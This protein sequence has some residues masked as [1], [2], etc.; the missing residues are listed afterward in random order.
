MQLRSY[1][2]TPWLLLWS[3]REVR[4]QQAL[5]PRKYVTS[6]HPW[7]RHCVNLALFGNSSC[8]K[9]STNAKFRDST[10]TLTQTIGLGISL[11]SDSRIKGHRAR[12][13]ASLLLP[14]GSPLAKIG[15]DSRTKRKEG[16][17]ADASRFRFGGKKVAAGVCRGRGDPGWDDGY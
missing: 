1:Q 7:M 14:G 9:P 10:A 12:E 5:I 8:F 16:R 13:S 4:P 3:L 17:G 2:P 6:L 15:N 11:R